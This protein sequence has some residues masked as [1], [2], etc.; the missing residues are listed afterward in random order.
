MVN[1]L[2]YGFRTLRQKP[3]FAL[4]A[5]VSIGLGVGANA[6]IFSFADGILLRPLAVPDAARVVNLR[7]RTPTGAY[8]G[9]SY[10]DYLDFRDHN[11]SFTGL[12]ASG[13]M[14]AAF[15]IDKNAQPRVKYGSMASGNF[16]SVLQ[17]EPRIGRGFRPSE[18][19]VPGR[20]AVMVLSHD[21]WINEFNS[22]SS[23]VGRQ[24]RLNGLD[25][26]VIGVTPESFT[27]LDLFVHPAFYVPIAMAPRLSVSNNTLLSDRGNRGFDV[28][29]RLK[30]GVSI[31]AAGAEAAALARS[32]EQSYPATNRAFGG[33]VRT[34]LQARND[35][36]PG[37]QV[38]VGLLFAI[39]MVALLIACANVANLL[40][41]R[42]RARAREI[43]VRLAIG[44]SRPRLIR[45]LL[46]E[47]L[48]IALSGGA[49]GLLFAQFGVA[50]LSNIQV[51]GDVPIKMA[52]ELD[53]RVLWFTLLVSAVSALLFG[54]MPALRATNTDL[55]PALKTGGP[56]EARKRWFGRNALVAVQVAF[57]L[58]LLVAASQLARGFSYLLEH[59]PGF[60][61]DHRLTMGFDP[62]V[63][64]YTPQQ[65]EQFYKTL[66]DQS[67]AL[68]GV[69]SAALAYA[70]PMSVNLLRRTVI[71]EGYQFPPG[72]DSLDVI[73]DI[74]DQHYFT[75]MGVPLERGRGFLPTDT[76]DAP[77]VAVVN[78]QFARH[79]LGPDPVGKRFRL[80][81]PNAPWVEV[82]GVTVTG[83]Y[84]QIFEGPLEYMYLPFSQNP[85]T[86]MTLIVETQGDPAALAHPIQE[87][88]RAVDPNLPVLGVRTLADLVEQRSVK[89]MHELEGLVA[90]AGLLGLSLALVGLYAVVAYQVSRRRRE[91]GIRMALGAARSEVVK[92]ILRQAAGM[93]LAGVGLGLLLSYAVSRALSSGL[94]LPRFD[95][96]LFSMVP[97][98]ML[99]TTLLAAAIPARRA[100]R[101]DPLVALRQD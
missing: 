3:G 66:L 90:S 46:T 31:E 7:T 18:D 60:R 32:L 14:P 99:L 87:M 78:A 29:G 47:S 74:V 101:V 12:A 42:G 33:A 84:L 80:N 57:S 39:V 20:D 83:K 21:F 61:A 69:K 71:P 51:P 27:G 62:S 45:Q 77:R 1:D 9:V 49:L 92:M 56:D 4:T 88:V 13:L 89:T 100:A 73:T 2:R 37:D 93:G 5:I 11:R 41:G 59:D 96:L 35:F 63:M 43:A 94:G 79:Y 34:E 72:K 48:L 30:P 50:T 25:F 52:F 23:V 10:P 97:L 81:D 67:Q 44:A 8:G 58:V 75:T 28:K 36:I 53:L 40:L 22:D 6:V 15:A 82:V 38:I 85:Q 17:A 64:S 54:L 19:E 91:I 95:P 55:T 68:P 16:F 70:I 86:E 98:G 24:V 76:A 26:T 65:T